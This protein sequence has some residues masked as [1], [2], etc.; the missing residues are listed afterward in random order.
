MSGNAA[1]VNINEKSGSDQ[2]SD[3]KT[4]EKKLEKS[5]EILI[6][7]VFTILMNLLKRNQELCLKGDF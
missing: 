2:K 1:F 5:V 4:L 6:P 7:P 3:L